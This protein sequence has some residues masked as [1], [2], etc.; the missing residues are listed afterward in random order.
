MNGKLTRTAIQRSGSIYMQPGRSVLLLSQRILDT[1]AQRSKIAAT[2]RYQETS[3]T[4]PQQQYYR[5]PNA[6]KCDNTGN[7][8]QQTR[9]SN[10]GSFSDQATWTKNQ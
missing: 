3:P 6:P 2:R 7:R 1:L 5:I 4:K 10:T 8:T 9:P